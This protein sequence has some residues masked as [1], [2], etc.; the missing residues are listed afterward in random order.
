[1]LSYARNIQITALVEELA[2]NGHDVSGIVREVEVM[3]HYMLECAK[4]MATIATHT[5]FVEQQTK[6]SYH[7]L[8]LTLPSL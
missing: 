3:R 4:R 2:D 6:I 8:L 5:E 7:L 1:L